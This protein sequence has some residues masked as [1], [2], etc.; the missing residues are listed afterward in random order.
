MKKAILFGFLAGVS[1]LVADE[2]SFTVDAI[3]QRWPWEAKIDVDFTVSGEEGKTYDANPSFFNGGT[4]LVVPAEALSGDIYSLE[5][6][7]HRLTLD[8]SKAAFG[9]EVLTRF[10]VVFGEV[11]EA[12][13]YMIVDLTKAKGADGL[14]TYLSESDLASGAY[15][16]VETNPVSGVSSIVWTG[17]TNDAAY[18]TTKMVFRRINPGTFTMG[19]GGARLTG[20]VKIFPGAANDNGNEVQLTQP[21]YIAVFPTTQDQWTR[22]GFTNRSKFTLDSARRP[23]EAIGTNVGTGWEWLRGSDS[24]EGGYYWPADGYAKNKNSYLGKLE[25]L[26]GLVCDLPTEAQWE[27]ACRAGTTTIYND[28][29]ARTIR[30]DD[31]FNAA[32]DD[33]HPLGRFYSNGGNVP[34]NTESLYGPTNGTANV[35]SYRPNAWGLY[36]MHGNVYEACLDRAYSATTNHYNHC[37]VNPAGPRSGSDTSHIG[38]GGATVSGITH[39]TSGFRWG[40]SCGKQYGFRVVVFPEGVVPEVGEVYSVDAE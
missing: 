18:A 3:H 20:N 11:A 31:D 27:Y 1:T 26:L 29:V 39:A 7:Q 13:L 15:G 8:P 25:D 34:N 40:W 16:T 30:S 22:L 33:V 6:G 9:N 21:Y 5:P 4:K 37:A 23:V 35:G 12:P 14:V 28:G 36:D 24:V 17:V 2:A 32:R 38:K 10:S 19:Y